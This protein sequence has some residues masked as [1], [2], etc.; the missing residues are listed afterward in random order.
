MAEENAAKLAPR[1]RAAKPAA[2]ATGGDG[3]PSHTVI[4]RAGP[5]TSR[6][7]TLGPGAN[8]QALVTSSLTTSCTAE[9]TLGATAGPRAAAGP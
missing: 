8:L 2:A 6:V 4:S 7:S 3:S 5:L 9:R 1:K